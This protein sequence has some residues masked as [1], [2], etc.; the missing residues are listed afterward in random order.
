MTEIYQRK[1]FKKI[2]VL[3]LGLAKLFLITHFIYIFPIP[4]TIFTAWDKNLTTTL[5][6]AHFNKKLL[7]M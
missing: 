4:L 5:K 7:S 3:I 6:N 1:Y 2:K